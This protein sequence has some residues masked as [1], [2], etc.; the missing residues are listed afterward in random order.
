MSRMLTVRTDITRQN[1]SVVGVINIARS[2]SRAAASSKM[3]MSC[4]GTDVALLSV[5]TL[6][7]TRPVEVMVGTAYPM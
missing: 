5:V 3:T 2:S 6:D 4:T 1:A 7:P